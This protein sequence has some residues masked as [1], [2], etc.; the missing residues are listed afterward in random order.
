MQLSLSFFVSCL[1]LQWQLLISKGIRTQLV[2]L[3]GEH[4]EIS[5]SDVVLKLSVSDY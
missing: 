4:C 2:K 3:T 5:K 1:K